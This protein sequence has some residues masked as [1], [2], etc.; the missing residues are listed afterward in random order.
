MNDRLQGFPEEYC[1]LLKWSVLFI[2]AVRCFNVVA[3]CCMPIEL[4]MVNKFSGHFYLS[5]E[6]P[7]CP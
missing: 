5:V 3:D 7:H 1:T 2:S 4:Q 6:N